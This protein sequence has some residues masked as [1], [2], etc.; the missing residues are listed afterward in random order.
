VQLATAPRG[1]ENSSRMS[2]RPGLILLEGFKSKLKTGQEVLDK[3]TETS[4]K[5]VF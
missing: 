5:P 1:L 4:H 3:A 2:C